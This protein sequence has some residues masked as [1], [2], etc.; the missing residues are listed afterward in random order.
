MK[1]RPY[2]IIPVD[3]RQRVLH[4][5]ARPHYERR[6]ARIMPLARCVQWFGWSEPDAITRESVYGPR[7]WFPPFACA[8]AVRE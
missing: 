2:P 5:Y 6:L 7:L 1:I 4:E 8:A 3:D